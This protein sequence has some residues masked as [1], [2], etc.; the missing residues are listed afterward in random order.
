MTLA[1]CGYGSCAKYGDAVYLVV[2]WSRGE[3]PEFTT[4]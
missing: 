1:G 2:G 4:V 3:W